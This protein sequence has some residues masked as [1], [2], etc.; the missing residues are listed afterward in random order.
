[1]G[2]HVVPPEVGLLINPVRHLRFAGEKTRP[3]KMEIHLGIAAVIAGHELHRGVHE[4]SG[5]CLQRG[6]FLHLDDALVDRAI[7]S[8]GDGHS[9]VSR[10][11]ESTCCKTRGVF[12]LRRAKIRSSAGFRVSTTWWMDISQRLLNHLAIVQPFFGHQGVTIM[13]ST[14]L[15]RS[16][17]RSSVAAAA[18]LGLS[19]EMADAECRAAGQPGDDPRA[20]IVCDTN[21]PNPDGDGVV[22]DDENVRLLPGA[23]I[24]TNGETAIALSG[25]E[26]T[27]VGSETNR[28]NISTSGD[29]APVV[30]IAPDDGESAGTTLVFTDASS[31]GENS[32]IIE[33]QGPGATRFSFLAA[34]SSFET[35]GAGSSIYSSSGLRPS[36]EESVVFANSDLVTRGNDAPAIV[37]SLV[38]FISLSLIETEIL[39]AGER[40][41]GLVIDLAGTNRA[42]NFTFGASNIATNNNES[43]ALELSGSGA[44]STTS[45][46]LGTSQLNTA[47]SRSHG[48]VLGNFLGDG[49]VSNFGLNS[50]SV[51]TDGEGSNGVVLGEGLGS[52]TPGVTSKAIPQNVADLLSDRATQLSVG[53]LSRWA[54]LEIGSADVRVTGNDAHALVIERGAALTEDET[55]ISSTLSNG[56]ILS[57]VV[58]DFD[59][60][61]ATGEGGSSILNHGTIAGGFDM[62]GDLGMDGG[63]L[64]MSIFGDD[65]YDQI[66]LTGSFDALNPFEMFLDFQNDF[67]PDAGDLFEIVVAGNQQTTFDPMEMISLRYGGVDVEDGFFSLDFSG[68]VLALSV[69]GSGGGT[70]DLAPIPLPAGLPMLL[71]ALGLGA[72]LKL[73]RGRPKA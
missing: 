8:I 9:R 49:T 59:D 19:A 22:G 55:R 48:L 34:E 17:L 68:G 3:V 10:P 63:L 13:I 7:C 12:F 32:H 60:F 20:T 36:D 53:S 15:S 14:K 66:A 42:D 54:D 44:G 65:D 40:S 47:G 58:S 38:D 61:V 11:K 29:D 43:T 5:G 45:F 64:E 23:S 73:R 67:I 21:A 6:G 52:A 31:D 24:A 69:N 27:A 57:G 35:S 37:T 39:T 51:R 4:S 25:G 56:T 62:T 18:I 1:M 30:V 16:L 70:P 28:A 33:Y 50:M 41:G 2:R 46:I 72:L 71:S 26:V